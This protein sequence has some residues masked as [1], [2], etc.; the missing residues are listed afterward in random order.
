MRATQQAKQQN[1]L[2]HGLSVFRYT[3]L[4]LNKDYTKFRLPQWWEQYADK[5]HENLHDF[6]TIKHYTIWHDIGKPHCLEID[7]EGKRHFPNHAQKSKEIWDASFPD[8]KDVSRLIEHDM[9]F[10]TMS[11]E[12]ILGLGLS[13]KDLCTLLISSLAELHSNA[14][15][16][17]G[18]D[19]DSFKI[20]FKKWSKTA[21]KICDKIFNHSYMYVLVRKDL[22]P[23]QQAVQSCHA[24]IEAARNYIG[25]KDEHPSVIICSV[26]SEQKLAMCMEELTAKGIEC[27]SF[28]EPDIGNQMTAIASRPLK[29]EERK[30]FSRF[31]LMQ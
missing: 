14:N 15:M 23:R 1:I 7:S 16:F 4:L 2:Q 27:Q 29:G 21:Q 20:K 5:I 19:S 30:A 3:N 8:R 13:D 25:P 10:H 22:S 26:K 18:I 28:R 9:A 17:G 31:Q 12:D 6:K 11:A 24:A